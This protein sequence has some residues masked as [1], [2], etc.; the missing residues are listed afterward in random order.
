[1]HGQIV[2]GSVVLL[3]QTVFWFSR[4]YKLHLLVQ[5]DG[6]TTLCSNKM[7]LLKKEKDVYR[8]YYRDFQDRKNNRIVTSLRQLEDL[9]GINA[10][11]LGTMFNQCN[12]FYHPQGDF[13]LEKV[14]VEKDTNK[15]RK[16]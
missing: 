8:Y 14:L 11:I 15:E 2:S 12:V 16:K 13:Y 3:G 10:R 1:M 9:C 7:H 6:I 5:I 4:N